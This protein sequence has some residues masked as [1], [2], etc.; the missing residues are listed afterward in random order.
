MCR[1]QECAG[2]H[3]FP[4]CVHMGYVHRHTGA[5][6]EVT[7]S[8]TFP[9]EGLFAR[10]VCKAAFTLRRLIPRSF[11]GA[12]NACNSSSDTETNASRSVTFSRLSPRPGTIPRPASSTHCRIELAPGSD[13]LLRAI[14]R[15]NQGWRPRFVLQTRLSSA[16][17]TKPL[18]L[19]VRASCFSRNIR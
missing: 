13:T 17:C 2:V 12:S 16:S 14:C 3:E 18:T 15:L 4:A 1:R 6:G 11:S 5:A 7:V 19:R 10:S 8:E 9:P